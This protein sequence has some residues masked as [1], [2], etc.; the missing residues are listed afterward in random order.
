MYYSILH[1]ECNCGRIR[2]RLLCVSIC[3]HILCVI[4]PCTG[5]RGCLYQSEV[6]VSGGGAEGVQPLPRTLL[7]KLPAGDG[8]LSAG[9][10]L[11]LDEANVAAVGVPHPSEGPRKGVSESQ[12]LAA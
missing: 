1:I 3:G 4:L 12:I 9:A 5:S 6:P 7:L 2:S 8:Q 11:S 10:A